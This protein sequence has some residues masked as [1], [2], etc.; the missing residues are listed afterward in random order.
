MTNNKKPIVAS[1]FFAMAFL[2]CAEA[3][4]L[5]FSA[6]VDYVSHDISRGVVG[7]D[8]PV[9]TA[10]AAVEWNGF[11]L[12]VDGIFNT[13]DIAKDE[14]FDSWDNTEIDYIFGYGYGFDA[15]EYGLPTTVE[16]AFNYIYEFDQ[17]GNGDN[18]NVQYLEGSVA[19]PDIFLS[20]AVTGSWMLNQFHGQLYTLELSHGF[21]LIEGKGDDAG[22]V[23]SLTLSFSQSLADGG[24]NNDD[25]GKDSWALRDSTITATLDWAIGEHLTISPYIAYCD[26]FASSVRALVREANGGDANQLYGGIAISAGF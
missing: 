6:G 23:L 24:Y 18:D 10:V 12:E 13:T 16:V 17:G 19:L 14:G 5:S 2:C 15:D 20:P 11:V 4:P 8:E 22:P 25:L 7:S 9:M 26:T 1:L 3:A 21:D